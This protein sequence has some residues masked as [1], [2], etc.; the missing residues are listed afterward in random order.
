ML[1][2]QQI[3]NGGRQ[4]ENLMQPNLPPRV[5]SCNKSNIQLFYLKQFLKNVLFFELSDPPE[6]PGL[7]PEG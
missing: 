5:L 2:I 1:R 3:K 4:K 7:T 6:T